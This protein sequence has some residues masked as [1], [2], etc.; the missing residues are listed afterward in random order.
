MAGPDG[1]IWIGTE[2]GLD[3]Y[4][5]R[6]NKFTHYRHDPKD[7]DS[8][9]EGKV[10]AVEPG[11]EGI[12]WIGTSLGGLNRFDRATQKFKRYLHDP[13]NPKTIAHNEVYSI[14]KAGNGDL[15]LGRSYAHAV[16]LEQI[17]RAHV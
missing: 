4:D 3:A 5:G 14:T 6:T 11:D 1:I 13:R 10:Y 9:G 15:W 2:T 16:G 7:D 17:G 12:L 8:I